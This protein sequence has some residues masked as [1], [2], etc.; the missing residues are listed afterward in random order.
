M[1]ASQPLD[2]SEE[3][4]VLLDV[5]RALHRHDPDRFGPRQRWRPGG[6]LDLSEQ[7]MHVIRTAWPLRASSYARLPPTWTAECAGGV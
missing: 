1:N 5:H 6:I 7:L 2:A 3:D 4:E